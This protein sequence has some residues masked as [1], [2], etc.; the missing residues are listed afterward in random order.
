MSA[1]INGLR[2]YSNYLT[3]K[4]GLFSTD[5]W[6]T[7]ATIL[8]NLLLNWL[9]L[10]PLIVVSFMVHRLQISVLQSSLKSLIV[11]FLAA[12]L[13]LALL[14]I[15]YLHLYCSSLYCL[16]REKEKIEKEEKGQLTASCESEEGPKGFGFQGWFILLCLVPLVVS[17]YCLTT[18]WAWHRNSPGSL[19]EITFLGWDLKWTFTVTGS[20][21]HVI[22]W[23]FAMLRTCMAA[24][25]G[26][27]IFEG[28]G[29]SVW[30]NRC[31]CPLGSPCSDSLQIYF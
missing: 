5:C 25:T 26:R 27:K 8:R 1:S 16:R 30:S 11:A 17:A 6:T 12:G 7:Y 4:L 19:S 23:S 21:I 13:F 22:G 15:T 14:S 29:R 20:L 18:A 31:I 9:V 3:P 24:K 28:S 2:D 10:I